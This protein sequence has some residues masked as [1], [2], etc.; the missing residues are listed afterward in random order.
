[1]KEIT[2]TDG[3]KL[4]RV[5]RWIELK[6]NYNP[7]KRN[8]LWDYVEDENGYHPYNDKFNPANGLYL[9]YFKF[10][11]KP[12]SL[13]QFYCIGSAFLGGEPHMYYDEYGKLCVIGTLY[14]DGP[15]FGP[16]LYGEWSECCEYVRLYEEV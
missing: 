12:Y 11:G 2:C 6:H 8:S 10:R 16:A 14:M 5:S 7:N 9:D 13:E 4:R 15:I 3:T 1:M